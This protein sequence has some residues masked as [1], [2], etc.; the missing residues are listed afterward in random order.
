[1]RSSYK[2]TTSTTIYLINRLH[3]LTQPT[4][5]SGATLANQIK[6][7]PRVSP[8]IFS[9]V[10]ALAVNFPPTLVKIVPKNPTLALVRIPRQLIVPTS[11]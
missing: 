10:R 11:R 5:R 7:I 1:M 9:H 3:S 4:P 2:K 8:I 6:N